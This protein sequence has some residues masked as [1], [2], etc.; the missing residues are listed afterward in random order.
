MSSL[1]GDR[2]IP[3]IGKTITIGK[4]LGYEKVKLENQ[5]LCDKFSQKSNEY[6]SLKEY[7]E[8]L[9]FEKKELLSQMSEL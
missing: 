5:E 1:Y 4:E 8:I 3:K 7:S 6:N 9:I 2:E